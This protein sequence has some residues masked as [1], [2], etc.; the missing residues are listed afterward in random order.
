MN[1]MRNDAANGLM[2][3]LLIACMLS[4]FSRVWLFAT[5]WTVTFQGSLSMGFSRQD[6]WSGLSCPPPGDLLYP[7]IKPSSLRSPAL[8]SGFLTTRATCRTLL[9]NIFF[10]PFI[11]IS[12]RLITSQHC[13]GFCHTLTWISHGVICIPHPDPPSHLPLHP[14]PLGLPSAPGPSACLIH[15]TWASDLF[16]FR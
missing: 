10:F 6:Y 14:I 4:R 15:P 13:S 5:P 7:G 8:A 1:D 2:L 16:H 11:F 3:I 12:W 9:L